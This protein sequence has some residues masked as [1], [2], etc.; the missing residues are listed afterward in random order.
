MQDLILNEYIIH[1][2]YG[3]FVRCWL[4]HFFNEYTYRRR[5]VDPGPEPPQGS[6]LLYCK[7]SRSGLF[8]T[9]G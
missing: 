7:D 4:L 5:A 1:L 3:N 8:G 9:E 6:M 2:Q